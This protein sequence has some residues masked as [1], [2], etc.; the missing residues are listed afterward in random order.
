MPNESPSN[1]ELVALSSEIVSSHVG[2]N[3]IAVADVPALIK[4]VHETLAEV[5]RGAPPE[6]PKPI[7]AVPIKK[8]ISNDHLTCLEDGQKYKMLKRHLATAHG[9]TPEEYRERWG[10]SSDYPMVAPNY[11]KQRSDLAIQIGLGRK[12]ATTPAQQRKSPKASS[13]RR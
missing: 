10:L 7:P 2:N 8:S 9:M 5:S 11:A 13:G 1:A 4:A 6:E 3:A 12:P